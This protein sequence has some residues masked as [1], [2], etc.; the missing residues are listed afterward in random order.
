[1]VLRV[2]SAR[3]RDLISLPIDRRAM[4]PG[5]LVGDGWDSVAMSARGVGGGTDMRLPASSYVRNQ[6]RALAT[7]AASR[8]PLCNLVGARLLLT[9]RWAAFVAVMHVVVPMLRLLSLAVLGDSH[10]GL[11]SHSTRVTPRPI[12]L[13]QLSPCPSHCSTY[14]LQ[15]FSSFPSLPH[16]R[17]YRAHAWP[18]AARFSFQQRD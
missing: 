5:R 1:M 15:R 2:V 14:S 8:A 7:A 12:H 10:C 9:C 3:D 11:N 6:T 16:S 4:D 18:S 13:R 17:L